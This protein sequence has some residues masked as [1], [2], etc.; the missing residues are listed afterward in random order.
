VTMLAW[1]AGWNGSRASRPRAVSETMREAA[2]MADVAD[3]ADGRR[4]SGR[5]GRRNA[6][7]KDGWCMNS[8]PFVFMLNWFAYKMIFREMSGTKF[9]I[10][11]L[12]Q[13]NP[14]LAS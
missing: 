4:G 9:E 13:I 11:G 12:F 3:A 7:Q 14:S 2:A 5:A 10:F 1:A 6:G 8:L